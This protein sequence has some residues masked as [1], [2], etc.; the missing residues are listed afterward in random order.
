MKR[1]FFKVLANIN[2]KILPSYTKSELD[3]Q[4]AGKFQKGIIAWKLWVT[5]NS[6]G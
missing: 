3:L 6:L 2:K 1:N 4:K 5:K